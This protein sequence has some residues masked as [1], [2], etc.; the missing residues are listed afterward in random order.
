MKAPD[1]HDPKRGNRTEVKGS[2]RESIADGEWGDGPEMT[3]Y[4]DEEWG[5][6]SHDDT[7]LFE[8]LVLQGAQAGLSWMTIL[9]KRE[10]YGRA[11]DG[12]DVDKIARYGKRDL[13]R[14]LADAGIVRNRGK[15]ES[16]IGN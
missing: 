1:E 16:A 6:P 12:F 8:H 7:H 2:K 9:R 13:A 5:V 3:A 11:F 14:L 4:H 15:I 10:G